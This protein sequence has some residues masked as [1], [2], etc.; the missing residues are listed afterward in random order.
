MALQA[1][2]IY[3]MS[4]NTQTNPEHTP[5]I[6]Q[7]LALKGA[8]PG[9]LLF[10]RM[11]DFYELF[12]QDAEIISRALDLTLTHRGASGGAPIPMA[13]VPYHA[14]E[15]YLA[16]LLK[17][18]HCVAI[19]EQIGAPT[20]TG[21][22]ERQVVRVL[23]PGTLTD[24][25]LL[26]EQREAWLAAIL[27]G[28]G[29]GLALLNL[30]SGEFRV[31]ELE[32][33][34]GLA[35]LLTRWSIAEVLLPENSRYAPASGVVTY[36]PASA[37]APE[38]AAR[39]LR[40]QFQLQDLTALGLSDKPLALAAAGALLAYALATQLTALPH[41][42]APR[43]E[44]GATY[45]LLDTQ[46]QRHLELEA[47]GNNDAPT[48]LTVLDRTKSAAGGR[49]LRRWLRRPLRD[50]TAVGARQMAVQALLESGTLDKLREMLSHCADL[51]RIAAR[52]ALR[53]ARPRDLAA[54]GATLAR[55]PALS[56]LL[57]PLEAPLLADLANLDA[58]PPLVAELTQALCDPAPA[59]TRDGG[60]F[61]AGYDAELDELHT[62]DDGTDRFLLEL[63][64]RERTRTGLNNL[65]V[66]YNRVQGFYIELYRSQ[67]EQVPAGYIRRQTLKNAERYITP[68]LKQYEERALSAQARALARERWLYERLLDTCQPHIALLQTNAAHLAELDVLACFAERARSLRLSCPTLCSE[69]GI[70]IDA[71]RHPVVEQA[72]SAA[73]VPNDLTLHPE[74]RLLLITGPTMGGKSTYLRQTALIVLLAY[75]G[76]FV[77]AAQ[78]RIGPID[79]IFTR[80]GAGDDLAG[81]RSTFMVEMSE[82]AQI[83]RHATPQSLVLLDEIGRGTSTFDG[84]SLA[85]ACAEHLAQ[86]NQSYT[87]FSTH[88]F[89]L[90]R[91][92]ERLPQV[93]NA[94]LAASEQNGQI[95]FLHSVRDGAASQ[96]Y[97]LQVAALAG[98]PAK[99]VERAREYLRQLEQESQRRESHSQPDL[100][101]NGASILRLL[102]DLRPEQ[103]TPAQALRWLRQL[104]ALA[105]GAS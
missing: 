34:A 58:C 57:A 78:V 17:L 35:D 38:A 65:K 96:S 12:F 98:I 73:F 94:H 50:L 95:V 18:G 6:R 39:L 62:L 69:S 51:E 32:D 66:G 67:A 72:S 5:F 27:P 31:A 89:E 47:S 33:T 90:T 46:T 54:L 104:K 100:F 99:V 4:V 3:S 25:A 15:Q 1:Q 64:A 83:L 74:R 85:W 37:F 2:S 42:Q 7:Y 56:A 49:L 20:G 91:L 68:E 102:Q 79:R 105:A 26:D 70:W 48:L 55:L 10:F 88:Y 59:H 9:N 21:P 86:V 41:L 28:D 80:I 8:Y 23:T 93:A 103:L 87:L 71:G 22:M 101:D 24:A 11:G 53:S 40:K 52:L 16:R 43:I 63:E 84:L 82:T 77:P 76:S 30:S 44:T 81:G 92:T 75:I 97:G 36:Q 13:G 60:I 14:A 19:A 45:L 61:A 29:Y